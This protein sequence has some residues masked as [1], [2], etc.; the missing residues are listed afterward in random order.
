MVLLLKVL[1]QK[2]FNL[3]CRSIYIYK[4]LASQL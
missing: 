3:P 4:R 1:Y 2:S